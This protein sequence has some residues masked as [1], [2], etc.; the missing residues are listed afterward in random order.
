[1]QQSINQAQ[2]QMDV[3]KALAQG[4][5]LG[6]AALHAERKA[7]LVISVGM[8]ALASCYS[9]NVILQMQYN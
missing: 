2:D 6:S 4:W 1:M 9:L 5:E 3:L 8:I 7:K